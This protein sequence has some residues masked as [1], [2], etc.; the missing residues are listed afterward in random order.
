[1]QDRAYV[2]LNHLE[3]VGNRDAIAVIEDGYDGRG[4][5]DAD[6]V[7]SLPEH[8]FGGRGVSDR[9]PGDLIPVMRE[10]VEMF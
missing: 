8:S 1:M 3:L 5:Q 9:C 10:L 7:E 6:G 4:V 2:L